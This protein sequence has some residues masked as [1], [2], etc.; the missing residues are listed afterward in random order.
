[1]VRNLH[2]PFKFG[3][4]SDDGFPFEGVLE[5]ADNKVNKTT[6]TIQVRGVVKNDKGLFLPGSRVRA[7]VAIG[8]ARKSLVV[9][10]TTVLSDQDKKYLL[11]VDDKNVVQRVDVALG[12]LQDDGMR[13]VLAG[14]LK[15]TDWVITDNLQA[16]RINYP[17]EPIRPTAVA[18]AGPAPRQQ[19]RPGRCVRPPWPGRS[20]NPA[21][22]TYTGGAGAVPPDTSG[23]PSGEV[24][25]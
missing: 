11:V 15:P 20:R 7:P 22:R 19:P 23:R 1:M 24:P 6:G 25:P 2:I 14:G 9:P 5:Y 13:V 3:R 4:E 10:D 12:R 16:A 18:A 21:V 17:A 8:E